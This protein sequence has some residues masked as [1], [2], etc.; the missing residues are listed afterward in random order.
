ML[1]H[2][3]KQ[4]SMLFGKS[5]QICGFRWLNISSS[6]QFLDSRDKDHAAQSKQLIKRQSEIFDSVQ[7]R[8]KNKK[9]FQRAVLTYL[10]HENVYRRGHVEFIYAAMEKMEEFGVHRDLETYKKILKI[11]PQGKMV[12]RSIWQAE[13]MH[14]PKQQNCAIELL[15]KMER[16]SKQLKQIA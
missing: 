12:P 13:F 5:N 6:L 16:N 11:F 8:E 4:C 2:V 3:R 10:K 14:Y 9:T 7:Q 15:E 1:G